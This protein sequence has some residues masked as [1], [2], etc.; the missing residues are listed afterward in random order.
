MFEHIQ[1]VI[2]LSEN[3][4]KLYIDGAKIHVC[5]D[6]LMCL[7]SFGIEVIILS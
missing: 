2:N 7:D 3:K 5:P 6:T 1:S 4:V